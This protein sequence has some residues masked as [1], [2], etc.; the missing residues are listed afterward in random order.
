MML[1]AVL[2]MTLSG[3][4]GSVDKPSFKLPPRSEV[5][6]KPTPLPPVRRCVESVGDLKCMTIIAAQ[7]RAVAA[8]NIKKLE[9]AGDAYDV[10]FGGYEEA[11]K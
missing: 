6:P 11:G 2:M 8:E 1:A 3:C 10:L 4:A 7:N 5:V 9:Q